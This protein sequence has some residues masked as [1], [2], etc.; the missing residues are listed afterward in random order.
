MNRVG[1]LVVA[2][3]GTAVIISLSVA[4]GYVWS[5]SSQ[6]QY[7][8]NESQDQTTTTPFRISE[9]LKQCQE[10]LAEKEKAVSN[11]T[12]ELIALRNQP[13]PTIVRLPTVSQLVK[14]TGGNFTG[15]ELLEAVN[16]YRKEH[17]V[18]E[19]QLKSSLCQLSS[20]R[21]GE[22]LAAGQLDNHE[23]FEAYFKEHQ[24]SEL[25]VTNVAENLASG[26]ASAWDTVMGWD[27]SPAHKTFLLA[28]GAYVWGCTSA[29]RGFAVLIG[30]Y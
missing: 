1:G 15:E 11:L 14:F 19:L 4:I 18:P 13:Q 3:L 28:D 16:K 21:L 30:G 26:Y 8:T 6:S 2:I 24:V 12:G 27:S 29:N 5:L 20:K 25:E 9:D 17:G 23:G 22:I 7:L 10:Q